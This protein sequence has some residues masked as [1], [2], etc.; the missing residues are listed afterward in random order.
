MRYE[1]WA[2]YAIRARITGLIKIGKCLCGN[3]YKRFLSAQKMINERCEWI[4]FLDVPER[5]AHRANASSRVWRE[6]FE[7]TEELA[8]YIIQHRCDAP[9][10]SR[11]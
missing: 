10:G 4:G 9:P 11:R 2:T 8:D 6:W 5:D 3:E 7:P 1:S